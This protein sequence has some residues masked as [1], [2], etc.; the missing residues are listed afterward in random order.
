MLPNV[1]FTISMIQLIHLALK[2]N[3]TVLGEK[4]YEKNFKYFFTMIYII[5]QIR[6][7]S[8]QKYM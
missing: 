1:A 7:L 8:Y 6:L 5:L 4:K 2:Q 3:L